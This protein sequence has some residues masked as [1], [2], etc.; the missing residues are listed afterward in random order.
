MRGMG[1]FNLKTMANESGLFKSVA[2]SSIPGAIGMIAQLFGAK[3]RRRQEEAAMKKMEEVSGLFNGQINDVDTQLSQSYLD[4]SDIQDAIRQLEEMGFIQNK[5]T[6]NQAAITGATD[7]SQIAAMGK[8]KN[9]QA[10]FL[11]K[12]MSGASQYRNMLFGQKGDAIRGLGTVAGAQYQAGMQNRANFNN[13][14]ANII[15]PLQSS[16]NAGFESGAFKFGGK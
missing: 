16:I 5:Q 14:V 13:S 12:L 1:F 8:T 10:D 4:N 2:V 3:R 7:E 9:T 15:Q 6:T 11:A